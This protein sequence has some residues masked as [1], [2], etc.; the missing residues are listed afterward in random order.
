[1]S[2]LKG[3]KRYI[4][5]AIFIACLFISN[6]NVAAANVIGYPP[7][8]GGDDQPGCD[9]G[10]CPPKQPANPYHRGCEKT[11]RCRGPS[12]PVPPQKMI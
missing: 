11:N 3:T 4:A 9:H 10:K 6:M 12:P 5:V 7:I 8:K 2:I 1:M